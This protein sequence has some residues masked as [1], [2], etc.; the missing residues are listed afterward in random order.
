MTETPEDLPG[1]NSQSSKEG[2]AADSFTWDDSQDGFYGNPKAKLDERGRLKMPPTKQPSRRSTA[3]SNAF[4]ITSQDGENSRDL[5]V[6][7]W[8]KQLGK[9]LKMPK[10]LPARNRCLPANLYGDRADMDPQ[11]APAVSRRV[12]H[13]RAAQ[14]RSES[15]RRRQFSARNEP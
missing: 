8:Q 11:G 4:Y 14:R 2:V 9:I 10:S 6:P 15:F 5:S 1:S 12:A 3:V 7:E 13:R